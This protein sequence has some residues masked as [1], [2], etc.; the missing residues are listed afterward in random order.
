MLHQIE[1]NLQKVVDLTDK[2]NRTF[3]GCSFEELAGDDWTPT[4]RIGV[5]LQNICDAILSY[6]AADPK[7]KN[8]NLYIINPTTVAVVDSTLIQTMPDWD[9]IQL[10]R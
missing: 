4:Q 1:V 8:L 9:H 3:L 5:Q 7:H 10:V 6:S 2:M